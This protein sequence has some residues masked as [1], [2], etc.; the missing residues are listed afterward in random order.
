MDTNTLF[1][2]AINLVAGA[3]NLADLTLLEAKL[4]EL[5]KAR[6]EDFK[7]EVK[8][9]ANADKETAKAAIRNVM[10]EA[11]V[12]REV[13]YTFGSGKAKETR[14]GK[15]LRA[16]SADHPTFTVEADDG[17]GGNKKLPRNAVAFIGFVDAVALDT[18]VQDETEAQ[19]G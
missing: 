9:A 16:P 2:N 6:K 8:A 7:A 18:T 19:V 11:D 17:K 5:V 13:R 15:L 12:G 14:T 1:T 4:K 10:T 3:A